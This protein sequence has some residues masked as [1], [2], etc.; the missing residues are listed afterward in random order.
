MPTKPRI[1]AGDAIR[2][3]RSGM[4]DSELMEKYELS[5]EGLQSL[6]RK[7]L[8]VKAITS[9]EIDQRR[10]AY[11][12]TTIIQRIDEEQFIEDIRSGMSD[13]E[14][15]KEYALSHDGL[16]RVF[17]MLTE[18]NAITVEELYG[19]SPSAHDSVFV[20]N[21]SESRG[22]HLAMSVEI[23]ESR[24]PEIRGML[25]NV[26]EKGIAII[27]IEACLG[28]AKT[29]VIP[30]GDFIEADPVLFEA[31]C[32]W[33]ERER[34]SGEWLAGFEIT[35]ISEKCLGDLQRLIQFLPFLD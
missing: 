34:D 24:R 33:A 21:M 12:D 25:S 5:A 9:A 30:A 22:H 16:R 11:H 23:C 18:A 32:Q 31:R 15:M 2:D 27:G 14:L 13:A 20:E 17:Q 3:I 26:T 29:F 6:V 1:K 19:T 10:A 4:S 35:R 8:E 28:E 7:L